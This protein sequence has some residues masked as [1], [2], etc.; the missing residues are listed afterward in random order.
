[1]LSTFT[2]WG[3]WGVVTAL[4]AVG[5]AVGTVGA[6][7]VALY[8]GPWRDRRRRPDLRLE[9]GVIEVFNVQ[10]AGAAQVAI[11]TIRVS[12]RVGR[13]AATAVQVFVQS[14]QTPGE[15]VP[16]AI[17]PLMWAA[18]R[19]DEVDVVAG[20]TYDLEL[21]RVSRMG[22]EGHLRAVIAYA[23]SQPNAAFYIPARGETNELPSGDYDLQLS[24]HA[25]N[26]DATVW[27]VAIAWDGRW[28]DRVDAI[29]EHLVVAAPQPIG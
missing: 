29:T 19:G 4:S 27:R 10:T 16:L 9:P 12:N 17:K 2:N 13:N 20:S 28:G 24:V 25:R 23:D 18:S 11:A 5:A 1:V 14:V 26:V 7:I 15:R 3:G 8:L 21:L 22:E 6:V